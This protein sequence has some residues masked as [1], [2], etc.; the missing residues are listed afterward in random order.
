MPKL[1]KLLRLELDSNPIN[2]DTFKFLTEH[3][4]LTSLSLGYNPNIA[5]FSDLTPLVPNLPNLH[6]I[7]LMGSPI[8]EL[9]TY[10]REIFEIFPKLEILDNLNDKGE[11]VRIDDSG[12]LEDETVIEEKELEV[13]EGNESEDSFMEKKKKKI[14]K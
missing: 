14:K 12:L 11:E 5:D 9:K 8:A 7:D 10:R 3:K 6:Q 1:S 2:P 4:T 13:D